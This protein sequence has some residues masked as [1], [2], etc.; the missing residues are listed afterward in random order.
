[1]ASYG[2]GISLGGGRGVEAKLD[3]ARTLLPGSRTPEGD[4]RIHF[5]FKTGF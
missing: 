5:S 2:A 1:L 3:W 4:S